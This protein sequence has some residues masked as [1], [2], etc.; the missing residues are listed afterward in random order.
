MKTKAILTALALSCSSFTMMAQRTPT[1]PLDISTMD[2]YQ[3]F[4][5]FKSWTPGQPLAGV[6]A[7]DDEFYISRVK[8]KKRIE[9]AENYK[10]NSLADKQR[11]LC[12]WVPLDD[13]SV[14]W[15]AFPRYSL[16]GD[17]FSMWS[18]LDIHGNWSAPWARVSAGLSDVAAK[19]GVAVGCVLGVP[20]TTTIT[21]FENQNFFNN[22]FKVLYGLTEA[23]SNGNFL[24]TR[25]LIQFMKYYGINGLGINSEFFSDTETMTHLM[26][27]FADCHK[28]AKEEGWEFQ[29]HWYDLMT[30]SGEKSFRNSLNS[31]NSSI[32]GP[33]NNKKVD[34]FFLNYKWGG[35][36]LTSSVNMA[37]RLPRNS[38]DIFAGFDIQK[39]GLN[40]YGWKSLANQ[41]ISIGFWGAH[42]Q[43]L[44][45]QSA[46]DEGTEDIAIQRAYQKK[47][48]LVFSGGNRNPAFTPELSSG[49]SLSNTALKKFHGLAS[50]LTAKSTISDVPFVSRFNL[51]NGL[52]FYNEGKVTFNHK[53]YNL[54]TQDLMPTWRWWITD[55]NDAVDETSIS[56]F[57]KTD[58]TFDEAYFG[59][60]CLNVSGKSAFSRLKLFKTLLKVQPNYTLSITY[61]KTGDIEP[62]AKLFVALKGDLTHYKEVVLPSNTASLSSWVT[63]TATMEQLGVPADSEVAMIGLVFNDTPEN[64]NMYVG[65]IALRNPAQTFN[66][67]TPTI[68]DVEIIRGR[69][70]AFDFKIRYASAPDNSATKV[71]NDDVD[72]W[73]YEIYMQPLNENPQLLTA[74]T[75]W[76][77]YVVDAPLKPEDEVRKVRLGV[78]AIAPDGK[79]TT[80]IVWTDYKEIPYNQM[81][82]DIVVDKKVVKPNEKFKIVM[83]DKRAP[84][85]QNISIV[86]PRNGEVMAQSS[87][88]R[89]C[90]AQI[91]QVG[92]YDLLLT[93]ANGNQT[94]TRGMVQITPETTGSVPVIEKVMADKTQVKTNESVTLS[95]VGKEG[96][97]KVSRALIVKDPEM[98]Y[99][100]GDIQVG[101]TYSYALWFKVE[102]FGHDKQGTNLINKNTIHDSWPHNNWGDLWVTIRSEM[103]GHLANEI[104]FNTMGWERHDSPNEAMM[105]KGYQVTPGVWTHVVV[106]HDSNNNQKLYFNGKKVAET[107]FT[108]S[109]RRDE[110]TDYRIHKN[111]TA[112]IFI[113]GGGVYKAGL[114]GYVDEVQVWDKAL[115]DDEVLQAMQGYSKENVPQNLKGYYTFEEKDKD[116]FFYNWGSAGKDEKAIIV[117][118]EGSGGEDTSKAKYQAHDSNNDFLGY[119]GIVGSLDVTTKANWNVEGAA[120]TPQNKTANATFSQP[121][122]Y[123]AELTLQNRWGEATM[124]LEDNIE[125]SGLPNDVNSIEASTLLVDI[126]KTSTS[127]ILRLHFAQAGTYQVQLINTAGAMLLQRNLNVSSDASEAIAF[128][129]E[130]GV[131]VLRILKEGKPY[132][133][134]KLMKK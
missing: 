126:S 122:T 95:Y 96:E 100:P 22:H 9:D 132:K 40:H 84:A 105:S 85:A 63:Y 106:T 82:S 34:M 75:S 60:S 80:D 65:E 16:E 114:N 73:Y 71:Y 94:T 79:A 131:Y 4:E 112:H 58:L 28:K 62:H 128:E 86:N 2:F 14:K 46:T 133:I 42:A 35:A 26:N 69:Y 24:W 56:L 20:E 99:I 7:T 116:G 53:W 91:S 44:L 97:G 78:R 47:L 10:A 68:K 50:Y 8:P 38:Y 59:G 89:V 115:S 76:A 18:Y 98:L 77:A 43:S 32:L 81:I 11:K 119:P 120:I 88:S 118:M 37:K 74:T 70:N 23:D 52:K 6:S 55:Q 83:V 90:E 31:Q 25:K 124:Q 30:S 127:S 15:K 17:N 3:W 117:T 130:T 54:N 92:L 109:S 39:D 125:V 19:N 21:F 27:F 121:G 72:T 5:G 103:P 45:H 111:R 51:G 87:N 129:G 12:M 36:S 48:E 1:H 107:T 29:I 113:G 108:A 123:K 110:S 64:Y 93:D 67:V 49:T 61:K 104:S 13:P 134:L 102:K 57:V 41:P 101:K 33:D 66:T